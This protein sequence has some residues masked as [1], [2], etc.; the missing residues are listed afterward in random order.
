MPILCDGKGLCG[1]YRQWIDLLIGQNG[2]H[3]PITN[4]FEIEIF[5]N[6]N[7]HCLSEDLCHI[8]LQFF[9][10]F[11]LMQVQE[12]CLLFCLDSFALNTKQRLRPSH[13]HRE[14]ERERERER[15]IRISRSHWVGSFHEGK[16]GSPWVTLNNSVDFYWWW[17]T[18]A[19]TIYKK[20]SG[21]SGKL[22]RQFK[23]NRKSS[24]I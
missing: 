15:A 21:L 20:R 6:C 10:F 9:F 17:C 8:S 24:N 14:R 11:S 5:Q 13:F 2:P 12:R 1:L 22:S 3:G 19:F 7:L 18:G 23:L 4:L 16:W